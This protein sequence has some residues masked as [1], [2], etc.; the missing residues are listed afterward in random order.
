MNEKYWNN[1][2]KL[3]KNITILDDTFSKVGLKVLNVGVEYMDLPVGQYVRFYCE[4]I[5]SEDYLEKDTEYYIK[6]NVYTEDDELI[7][8]DRSIPLTSDRFTGYDTFLL[9][10]RHHVIH[11]KAAK[12]RIY[13]T[14]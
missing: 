11:E 4:V 1:E 9:M 2:V 6:V 14:Q 7:C 8:M 5:A 13:L 12:A 10:A 3:R